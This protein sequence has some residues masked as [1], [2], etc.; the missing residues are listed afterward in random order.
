MTRNKF[1][2]AEGIS[3]LTYKLLHLN[4]LAPEERIIPGTLSVVDITPEAYARWRKMV[5]QPDSKAAEI[6]RRGKIARRRGLLSAKS[7][8]HPANLIRELRALKAA[9]KTA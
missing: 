8:T 6:V 9:S 4:K 3:L 7:P 1:C 2:A 5:Q